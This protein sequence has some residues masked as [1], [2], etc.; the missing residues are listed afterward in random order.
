MKSIFGGIGGSF[1]GGLSQQAKSQPIRYIN[2]ARQPQGTV[3]G[4]AGD[5]TLKQIFTG[6]GTTGSSGN[7][8]VYNNQTKRWEYV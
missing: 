5:S 1:G 7:K 6:G 8:R 3:L 4:S 2:G